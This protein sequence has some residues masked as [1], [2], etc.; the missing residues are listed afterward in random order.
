MKYIFRPVKEAEG[1]L[2]LLHGTG[3][4]ENSL[5][6]IADILS[7][8]MNVLGIRGNIEENGMPRFFKRL[9]E[10]VFDVEDLKFRTTELAHFIKETATKYEFLLEKIYLV[11]YSNGANIAGNLLLSEKDIAKGAILLHPMVPSREPTAVSLDGKQILICA[12]TVDPLIAN[13]EVE[14]LY[15]IMIKKKATTKLHWEE[16]DHRISPAEVEVARNWLQDVKE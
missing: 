2:I 16:N 8:N 11:G 1:T 7:T 4:D 14:E 5:V 12:G 6:Q 3:G 9:S 15:D 13:S 10:G